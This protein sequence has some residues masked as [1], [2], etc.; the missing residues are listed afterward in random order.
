MAAKELVLAMTAYNL[1]RAVT[2]LAAQ[3]AGIPLHQSPEVIQ[4]FAPLI[5][6]AKNEHEGE[7]RP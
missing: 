2:C 7:T 6:N 1:V 3:T 5:A 4:T